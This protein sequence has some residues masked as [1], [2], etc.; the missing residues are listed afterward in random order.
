[1]DLSIIIVNWNSARFSIACIESI[2]SSTGGPGVEIIVVDNASTDGSC[3]A[4]REHFP[5]LKL[6]SSPENLGF[7]RANNLGFEACS[8]RNV[9]FLNPDTEIVGPAVNLMI[10]CLDSCPDI[11]AVGCKLLNT[12]LTVQ[13]S[14]IQPYPTILN[15]LFDVE[16]LRQLFPK[17]QLWGIRPLFEESSPYP[18]DV[19]MV[20]GAGLMAKRKALEQVG[21]FNT[22]Y[23]MYAEDLDLCYRMKR[24]GWKVCYLG[25]ATIVHHG[26]QS[27]KKRG[28]ASFSCPM[29]AEALTRFLRKTRGD[30]YAQLYRAA[31]FLM[32]LGR[33]S[34]L[35]AL[36]IVT[37][38]KSNR[39]ILYI[40]FAK[41]YRALRWSIGCEAWTERIGADQ[42]AEGSAST[43][44][45]SSL[46]FGL[47]KDNTVL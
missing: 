9:L 32:A 19:D 37:F 1:M 18:V 23:F 46:R 25:K 16:R 41:W 44:S 47:A 40:S 20:S 33:L 27:A 34:L 45:E 28:G 6:I 39:Q 35:A 13:T 15:Q 4:L 17:V 3:R 11:G 24:S 29:K 31:M 36:L 38:R 43:P 10:A 30:L 21:L 26:G 7:A 42:H 5:D 14:C 8:G 2:R 22:D 12:D